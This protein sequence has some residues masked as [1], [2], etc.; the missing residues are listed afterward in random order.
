MISSNDISGIIM[1][2]QQSLAASMQYAAQSSNLGGIGSYGM[3][4]SM[5]MSIPQSPIYHIKVPGLIIIEQI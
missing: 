2:Q 3:P 5:G 4:M 1:S